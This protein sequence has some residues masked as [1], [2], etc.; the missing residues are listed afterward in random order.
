MTRLT[1]IHLDEMSQDTNRVFTRYVPHIGKSLEDSKTNHV[2]FYLPHF[3]RKYT[4]FP[5][6]HQG[7][8]FLAFPWH[9]AQT[10]NFSERGS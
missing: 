3:L 5:T 2:H 9:C 10:A 8:I 4:S 7:T 6:H 1:L